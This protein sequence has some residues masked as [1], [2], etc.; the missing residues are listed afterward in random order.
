MADF[1]INGSHDKAALGKETEIH[2]KSITA[3]KY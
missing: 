3:D 1:V 2:N